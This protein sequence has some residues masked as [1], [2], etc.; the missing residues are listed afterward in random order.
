M[1]SIYYRFKSSK[2]SSRVNIDGTSLSV[3]DLKKEIILS[4]KMGKGNDFDLLLLRDTPSQ[5]EY[6]DDNEMIPRST[7]VIVK[8]SPPRIPNRGTAAKYA[9]EALIS[10]NNINNNE[11]PTPNT[12]SS[13]TFRPT[14]SM[15]FDGKPQPHQ[16]SNQH[17]QLLQNQSNNNDVSNN[18]IN[19]NDSEQDAI[20]AMFAAS[21]QQ[22]QE[23]QQQMSQAT[24]VYTNMRPQTRKPVQNATNSPSNN[25][26]PS[27]SDKSNNQ[28]SSTFTSVMPTP[29]GYV[30]Y[31]CGEKGWVFI[32]NLL[33]FTIFNNLID[34]GHWI[35][36]CPTNGDPEFE[37]KPRF[38]RT[39]GIPKSFLKTVDAATAA[40][41]GNAGV[42]I[43]P[44]GSHVIATPDS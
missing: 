16:Q 21:E 28:Q 20:A 38:K 25:Q 19:A 15:R 7:S 8:R 36:D 10:L 42:M 17:Q 31:R 33:S 2:T 23:T 34:I 5:E 18:N 1:G 6:H 26:Q 35:Q 43:T 37:N 40:A 30:C 22:W 3:F 39:T 12:L 44:D 29:P 14:L 4:N 27:S 11:Q 24:P 13:N 32:F 9:A 41:A